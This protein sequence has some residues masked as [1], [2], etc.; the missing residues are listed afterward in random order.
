M[1]SKALNKG[2]N[3]VS[4]PGSSLTSSS[5]TTMS[6]IHFNLSSPVSSNNMSDKWAYPSPRYYEIKISRAEHP[7]GGFYVKKH[8]DI[9]KTYSPQN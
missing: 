6:D 5:S 1:I 3:N 9:I 8:Q 7:L 2:I 4:R